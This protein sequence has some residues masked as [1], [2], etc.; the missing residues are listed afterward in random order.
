[1]HFEFVS[2]SGIKR[3]KTGQTA[4]YTATKNYSRL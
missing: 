1:M 2:G 4:S 3:S